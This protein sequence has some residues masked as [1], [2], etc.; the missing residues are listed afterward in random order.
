[1][2]G[3]QY[4]GRS[5]KVGAYPATRGFYPSDMGATIYQALGIEPGSM[6]HDVLGR[7]LQLN[8]GEV[9]APLYTASA[10]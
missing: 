3:G 10:V 7:P 1:V 5:D 6:V 4:V 9:M 2:R 8:Q